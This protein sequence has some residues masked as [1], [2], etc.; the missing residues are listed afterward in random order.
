MTRRGTALEKRLLEILAVVD[1]GRCP[2]AEVRAS[3]GRLLPEA[4]I[5]ESQKGET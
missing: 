3:I 2:E 5:L 4:K 1:A